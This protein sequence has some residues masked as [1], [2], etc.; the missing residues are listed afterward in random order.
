M[1][2]ALE[3]GVCLHVLV[4]RAERWAL[5]H[6]LTLLERAMRRTA[7]QPPRG[8]NSSS[9]QTQPTQQAGMD[10]PPATPPPHQQQQQV[11]SGTLQ[12]AAW[13]ML[14]ATCYQATHTVTCGVEACRFPT[15]EPPCPDNL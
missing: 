8:P 4:R 7:P 2:L 3:S 5:Y 6:Q 1:L 11:R 12:D 13:R 9:Q 10:A 15:A 14:L